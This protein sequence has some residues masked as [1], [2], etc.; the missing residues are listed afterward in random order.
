M[1]ISFG[2]V[3]AV[4]MRETPVRLRSSSGIL[5]VCGVLFLGFILRGWGARWEGKEWWGVRKELR[6]GK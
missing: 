2:I 3:A 1:R 4:T 6:V 5:F